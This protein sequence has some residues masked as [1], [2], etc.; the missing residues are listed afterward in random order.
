M[1]LFQ[2]KLTV[3]KGIHNGKRN[4]FRLDYIND[5]EK[6]SYKLFSVDDNE[7]YNVWISK[8]RQT[9]EEYKKIGNNILQS[10]Q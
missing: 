8:I 6:A 10:P 5:K 1:R 2:L 3:M 7:Q 4:V 9:L